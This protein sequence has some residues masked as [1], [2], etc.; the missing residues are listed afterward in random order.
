MKLLFVGHSHSIHLHV[1]MVASK[2]SFYR[3]RRELGEP[4]QAHALIL[5]GKHGKPEITIKLSY[6]G[7][8]S[9]EGSLGGI[10]MVPTPPNSL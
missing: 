3:E 10:R 2:P 9:R 5:P 6:N 8:E 1:I 7:P 4:L